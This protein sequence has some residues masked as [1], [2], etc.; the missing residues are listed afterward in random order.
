[1]SGSNNTR[2]ALRVLFSVAA[3]AWV[4]SAAGCASG[5]G[6]Q[7][8]APAGLL[9]L[10]AGTWTVFRAPGAA[11]GPSPPERGYHDAARLL[12]RVA[13]RGGGRVRTALRSAAEGGRAVGIQVA[14]ALARLRGLSGSDLIAARPAGRNLTSD[15]A[16]SASGAAVAATAKD[17]LP[18][19]AATRQRIKTAEE[20]RVE[21]LIEQATH[22][23]F[24]QYQLAGRTLALRMP[25]GL[26]GEREG[27]RGWTQLFHLGG[28]GTPAELWPH[29]DEVLLSTAFRKYAA[30]LLAEG[31]KVVVF[32]LRRKSYEVSQEPAL[33]EALAS[34]PYPGSPTRV[35]VRR[36]GGEITEADLY[37]YLYAVAAVGVDCSGLTHQLHCAV[38][39]AYGVDLDALLAAKWK[40]KPRVVRTRIGLWFY[41]PASGYTD[42][43]DDRI[44]NLRPGDVLLFRGRDGAFKHSAVI[45]SID[46]Q[47]GLLRYVQSTDW[48][49]EEERGVHLSVARFDPARPGVG[50]GH[51]SVRWLQQVRP[52]FRGELEPADWLNDGDRYRW[53]PQA[54]GSQVVRL[55]HLAAALLEKAPAYYATLYGEEEAPTSSSR[56]AAPSA[57]PPSSAPR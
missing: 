25:F 47:H 11:D 28:K 23:Y 41:D 38:A 18:A 44:D 6:P 51:Y 7:A 31:D 30:A 40:V 3:A 14:G 35:Y 26:N 19:A 13:A 39:G 22:G 50:L 34:G 45:Q 27:G 55:R 4:L 42:Q 49:P 33:L 20:L 57:A 10:A 16:R 56:W 52:P 37:N 32:D 9:D 53:Y 2:I 24:R 54:G 46:L 5:A 8:G 21:Q 29:I 1:M 48:A 43:V 36:S 17:P 12:D 15:P